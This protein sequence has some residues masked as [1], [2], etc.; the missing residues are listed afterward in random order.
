MKVRVRHVG[1]VNVGQLVRL[2]A[3]YITQDTAKLHSSKAKAA[4]SSTQVRKMV[5]ITYNTHRSDSYH[6]SIRH[7]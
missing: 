2:R 1:L 3:K 6:L 7:R 4:G 5:D